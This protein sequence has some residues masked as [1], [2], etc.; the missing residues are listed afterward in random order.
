[1]FVAAVCAV[2]VFGGL[3]LQETASVRA[4]EPIVRVDAPAVEGRLT[5]VDDQWG[6]SFATE[7]A[8]VQ[9]S[10][11][12]L[13]RWGK[14]APPV[15]RASLILLRPSGRLVARVA[16]LDATKLRVE[17]SR[18]GDFKI[19]R[20]RALGWIVRAP[21]DPTELEEL[22]AKIEASDSASRQA[23]C[24]FASGRRSLTCRSKTS[25]P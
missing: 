8:A 5:G 24:E 1:M 19:K 25:R 15:E 3:C 13:V 14:F 16:S 20:Q 9:V 4:D 2:S 17:S 18:L 12:R 7:G 6:F 11:E 23:N 22:V 21:A 10:A